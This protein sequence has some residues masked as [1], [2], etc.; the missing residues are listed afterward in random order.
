ME[1]FKDK[2]QRITAELKEAGHEPA[3][4]ELIFTPQFNS[5]RI[6]QGILGETQEEFLKVVPADGERVEVGSHPGSGR[7]F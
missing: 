1:R 5:P 6:E 3:S 2:V 7:L 4:R